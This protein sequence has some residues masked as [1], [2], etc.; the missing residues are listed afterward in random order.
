MIR[1]LRSLAGALSAHPRRTLLFTLVFVVVAGVIGGPLAGS[2]QSSG[3]FAPPNSDSQVATRTLERATGTEP[4]PGIV[5]LVNT[6]N[7]ATAARGRTAALNARLETV[8]GV[9]QTVAPASVS[10]DGRHV[11]ITATLA[12]AADDK[13]A[14]KAAVAAFS[15]DRDVTVGGPQVANKQV[16]STV[17]QDLGF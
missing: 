14:A 17:T 13:Q 7:G 2:L 11:L 5:L 9:V 12:A 10:R 8:P 15:G 4:V 16:S 3:G 1:M 6:P